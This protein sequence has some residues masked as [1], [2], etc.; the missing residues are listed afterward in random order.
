MLDPFFKVVAKRSMLD[1]EIHE[2]SKVQNTVQYAI[3]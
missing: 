2:K 1:P 3:H